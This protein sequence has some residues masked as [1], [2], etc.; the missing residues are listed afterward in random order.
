MAREAV[1]GM[2]LAALYQ[3]MSIQG[4]PDGTIGSLMVPGASGGARWEAGALDAETGILYVASATEPL[5]V[6]LLSEPDFSDLRYVARYS[7]P[8][9]EDNIPLVNPPWGRITAIDLNTGEHLWVVP[10][11]EAPEEVR[12]SPAMAGVDLS[13]AGKPLRAL[14]LVTSTLLF[15]GEGY[16]GDPVFRALDKAT[17]ETVAR[18]ELPAAQTGLPISYMHEGR[19]YIVMTVGAPGHPAELVALALPE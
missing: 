1:E 19:Q 12:N 16:Q 10:N 15:Y 14:T 17:G 7:F 13:G 9:M 2:R 3:P 8:R 5:L 18:V 6:S 4:T 11:G